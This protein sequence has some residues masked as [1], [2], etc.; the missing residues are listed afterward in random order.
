MREMMVRAKVFF[1]H[2]I[3]AWEENHEEHPQIF[4]I[5]LQLK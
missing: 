2:I 1:F 5:L 3:R 4:Q